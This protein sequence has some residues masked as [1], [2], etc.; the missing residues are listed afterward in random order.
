MGD[1]SGGFAVLAEA[2]ERK[3][4]T[5]TETYYDAYGRIIPYT[6]TVYEGISFTDV[7]CGLF[8]AGNVQSSVQNNVQNSVQSKLKN[9]GLYVFDVSSNNIY[10]APFTY[11]AFAQ[12]SFGNILY[13]FPSEGR[14]YYRAL[15]AAAGVQDTAHTVYLQDV[16]GG[17]LTSL[18][19]GDK[20]QKNWNNLII[21]W[22]NGCF[23][24]CGYQQIL[25][26][27]VHRNTRNVFYLNK[28]IMGWR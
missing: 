27:K 22:Y 7:F 24:A 12:D 26:H 10:S 4:S 18:Y 1:S 21:T 11:S 9:D 16:S 15:P 5:T 17:R 14:V 8:S 20:V 2:Y 3:F 13:A 6:R 28:L 25:N 19:N 23:L